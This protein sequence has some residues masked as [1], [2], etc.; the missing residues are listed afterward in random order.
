ME[1]KKHIALLA[2]LDLLTALRNAAAKSG[3]KLGPEAAY[4]LRKFYR[5]GPFARKAVKK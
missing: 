3:R 2:D 5:I 1:K 4:S